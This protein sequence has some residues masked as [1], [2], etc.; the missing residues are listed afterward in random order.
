M[1]TLLALVLSVFV[2]LTI[3]PAARATISDDQIKTAGGIKL[4]TELLDKMDKVAKAVT[5]DEAA[6]TELAAVKETELDATVAGIN[7]KCPKAVAYF[8]EAGIT[9]EEFMKGMGAMLACLM[10]EADE[11][12]KSDNETAKAN[13]DFFKANKD[14]CNA[15]GG[16]V[17]AMSSGPDASDP[18]KKP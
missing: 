11:L 3:V 4:T 15:V 5:A 14:R 18:A 17:M 13:A 12:A 8:K 2:G 7:S 6:R 16:A 1:K 10:D 9:V